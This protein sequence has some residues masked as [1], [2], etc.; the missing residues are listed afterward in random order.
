[1]GQK[2]AIEID[3][4]LPGERKLLSNETDRNEQS[5]ICCEELLP[6]R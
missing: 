3:L 6:E 5:P 4:A 1:M 2:G